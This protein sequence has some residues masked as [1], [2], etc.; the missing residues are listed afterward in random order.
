[1][2]DQNKRVAVQFIEAMGQN[3]VARFA[4]CLAPDAVAVAKGTTK[5]AGARDRDMMIGGVE[6][7]GQILP[8]GLQFEIVSATSDGDR[9][10]VEAQGNGTTAQGKA[11]HNSYCFVLT[12]KDGKIVHV[13]EYFCTKLADE[14]LWPMVEGTGGLDQT[15]G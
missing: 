14:V 9:V 3:D 12:M 10:A 13:N 2:S 4:E 8:D 5:F 1:M 7:F 6:A 15:V 11:Y